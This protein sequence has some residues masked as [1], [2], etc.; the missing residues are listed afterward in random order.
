[1]SGIKSETARA[2]LEETR[3]LRG[4]EY[5]ET[6]GRYKTN[7]RKRR[8][9]YNYERKRPYATMQEATAWY[10]EDIQKHIKDTHAAGCEVHL[11]DLA[12]LAGWDNPQSV[13]GLLAHFRS[14]GA[15]KLPRMMRSC[16]APK[17]TKIAHPLL[18]QFV[19]DECPSITTYK[20]AAVACMV[21]QKAIQNG[22]GVWSPTAWC[23]R[24]VLKIGDTRQDVDV[25]T[26]QHVVK[27]MCR[28]EILQECE[29]GSVRLHPL[30]FDALMQIREK[31]D[32]NH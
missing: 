26:M 31:D 18:L 32:A 30:I 6:Q 16:M 29:R 10:L 28:D 3:A 17:G 9:Y 7:T 27:R 13:H 8:Y 1:M 22:A 20:Q 15:I 25:C 21:L 23:L 4:I 24:T 2:K 5:N 12:Q 19:L 14:I 11:S